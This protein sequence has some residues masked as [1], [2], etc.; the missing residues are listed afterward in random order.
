MSCLYEKK[1]LGWLAGWL[2]RPLSVGHPLIHLGYA[3][4]MD[5]KELA[6]E[7]LGL[8][9][10]EYD[11]LHKY[12]DD[13]SYRQR[14][15]SATAAAGSAAATTT[16]LELLGKMA[17]DKRL[18]GLFKEPGGI[19]N[20]EALFAQHEDLVL[21]YWNA[22][23]PERGGEDANANANA[24][25]AAQFRASQEAATALLVATVAPGAHAYD[26]FLVHI[27]TTSHAVRILLP[28][29]PARHHLALLRQ[30]WLLAVAVYIVRGC[31]AVDPDY[32]APDAGGKFWDHVEERARNGPYATDA[33]FLKGT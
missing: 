21:E 32:V 17:R 20:L 1:Q 24:D 31:P 6:I 28:V 29:V 14:P 3:Y 5:N 23:S 2:T 30:W 25:M 22:W 15:S 4:E 26:F 8:A 18:K 33:H 11:F 9:S 7:A 19:D 27:L 10:V 13:A 16:P 12:I